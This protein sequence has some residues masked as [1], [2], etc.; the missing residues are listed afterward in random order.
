LADFLC[1]FIFSNTTKQI[2]SASFYQDAPRSDLIPTK[3][4]VKCLRAELLCD[5]TIH[6]DQIV[7]DIT[8]NTLV[9]LDHGFV[10]RKGGSR[11]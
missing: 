8:G 4:E 7:A 6:G 9:M 5:S 2:G 1:N 10:K 3:N 11:C